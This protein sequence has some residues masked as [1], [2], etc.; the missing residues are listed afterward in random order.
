MLNRGFAET[1]AL[2]RSAGLETVAC[3]QTDAQWTDREVRDQLDAL[4]AHRVYFATASARDA[5]DAV[6]V[7]DGRVLRHGAPG[8]RAPLRARPSR[9]PPAPPKAP[10]DRELE[11]PRGTPGAVHRTDDP[12]AGRPGPHRVA[13]RAPARARRTAPARDL[14]Q[15]HWERLPRGRAIRSARHDAEVGARSR[16]CDR[17]PVRSACAEPASD[18]GESYRELVELD[19][20]HSVRWAR[21]GRIADV[22]SSPT[23]STR[24][25]RPDRLLPPRPHQPDPPAVQR[26]AGGHDDAAATEATLG[27]R[28][29]RALP[30]PSPRRRRSADVLRDHRRR[31]RAP[32]GLPARSMRTTTTPAPRAPRERGRTARAGS[33][34]LAATF[35]SPGGRSRSSGP[36]VLPARS[37]LRSRPTPFSLLRCT[38]AASGRRPLGPGGPASL[39]GSCATRLPSHRRPAGASSR[40]S[41]SRPSARTR[42]SR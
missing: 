38:R 8:H 4:F 21:Q 9:R 5:R 32:A 1:M 16:A 22:R 12:A 3:W 14:R 36:P 29:R 41:A 34:R 15:P 33:N 26:R 30:V 2:K 10:R 23:S 40:S 24:D 11:H 7:D 27:C 20:A 6:A 17:K 39:R 42:S 19:G 28:A 37:I 13:R 25:P 35:T 18:S 31:P